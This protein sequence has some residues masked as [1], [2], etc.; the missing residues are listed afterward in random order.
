MRGTITPSMRSARRPSAHTVS[1]T[2][3]A[4]VCDEC[5]TC[6]L[7]CTPIPCPSARMRAIRSGWATARGAIGKNVASAAAAASRSSRRDVHTGSG[8]SSKVNITPS[9]YPAGTVDKDA[10]ST[11]A[12]AA[13]GLPLQVP[14]D[15]HRPRVQAASGQ[16]PAQ[17]DHP[18]PYRRRRLGR[19]GDRPARPGLHSIETTLAVASQEALEMPAGEPAL[20]CCSSDRQL[21]GHDLENG[22]AGWDMPAKEPQPRAA[23]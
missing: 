23:G 8:P 2:T 22:D 19:V 10:T 1:P 11:P 13:Y 4:P 12:R 14:G 16:T 6:S 9:P 21:L 17:L 3:Q 7:Q 20:G 18:I 5:R 15:R